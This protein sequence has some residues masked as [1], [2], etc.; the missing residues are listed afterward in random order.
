MHILILCKYVFIYY[1]KYKPDH[2]LLHWIQCFILNFF[3]LSGVACPGDIGSLSVQ[4]YE[5]Q[6]V[7]RLTQIRFTGLEMAVSNRIR[8]K[9][10]FRKSGKKCVVELSVM[11]SGEM[12]SFCGVF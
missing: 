11:E 4:G 5:K 7:L 6:S 9:N 2:L 8:C 3:A 12:L 1:S 10:N